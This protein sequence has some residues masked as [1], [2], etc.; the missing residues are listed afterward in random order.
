MVGVYSEKELL[1]DLRDA[2]LSNKK[3]MILGYGKHSEPRKADIYLHIKMDHYEINKDRV[4]AYAGASIQK[5]REEASEEGLLLP[6]F[7]DG[8]VGG[9]LANNPISPLTTYYGKPSDFTEWVDFATPYKMFRW[10]GIVGSK[11]CFGAI[12]KAQLKLYEKPSKVYT[13]EATI[14]DPSLLK[15]VVKKFVNYTPLVLL[16]EYIRNDMYQFHATMT[17]NIV[18]SGFT[19]DEG[20][21]N[22]EESNKNSYYV[23][24]GSI[25]EF[26]AL[27]ERINPV[28][29]YIVLNAGYSKVYVTDEEVLEKS[30][31]EYFNANDA[32]QIYKKIK[33]IFDF[34]NIFV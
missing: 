20:V 2:Y 8:S 33:R 15:D 22:I 18:V 13:Y 5:I 17:E 34:K 31:Y 32:P 16:V 7:Y 10:K 6:T 30:G 4:L 11:G 3:I 19:K 14:K 9:L 23:K 28:Y 1:N 26:I 27:T 24:T 29:A 25:E 12:T 21:P